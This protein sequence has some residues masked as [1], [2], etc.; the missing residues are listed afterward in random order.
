VDAAVTVSLGEATADGRS[1]LALMGLGA[2]KGDE[3]T[4]SAT[5]AQATDALRTVE[6]LA[7]DNF[8]ES[9]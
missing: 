7:A 9:A 5:G 8:G 4:V 1:V 3:L 6:R 2:R